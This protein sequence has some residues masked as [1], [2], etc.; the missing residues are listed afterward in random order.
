MFPVGKHGTLRQREVWH[1]SRVSA[2]CADPPKPRW[3]ASPSAFAAIALDEGQRLRAAKRDGRCFFDQLLLPTELRQFMGRPAVQREELIG[4][5]A[6]DQE[7]WTFVDR[8]VD[9]ARSSF[10]PCSNVWGMGFAWSSFIA[11]ESLL[12]VC[13]RAGLDERH[14]LAPDNDVPTSTDLMFSLAT[15][16]VMIFSSSGPGATIAPTLRVEEEMRRAGIVK[17]EGKDVNDELSTVCVGVELVDGRWWW[18]PFERMWI[19]LLAAIHLAETGNGSPAG[20]LAMLGVLQWFDLMR[21]PKLSCYHSVYAFASNWHDWSTQPV[22]RT[23][24]AELVTSVLLSAFWG[25]DMTL[26]Y[27]PFVAATDASDEFGIGACVSDTAIDLVKDIARRAERDGTYVTI[28]GI[29]PKLRTRSLG[30]PI[31]VD[32]WV[33]DF[34]TVFSIKCE[35]AEHINL[36]EARALVHFLKWVLRSSARH[37]ARVV[38]LVDSRVVVGATTKGRSG[39]LSLNAFLKRIA[40]LCFAGGIELVII[41][42]P[43]EYNPADYPSR[44]LRIPG[45][46]AHSHP[47][48]PPCPSCGLRPHVHPAHV[49]KRLRGTGLACQGGIEFAFVNGKWVH[50]RDLRFQRGIDTIDPKDDHQLE[51]FELFRSGGSLDH[52]DWD[53]C[54]VEHLREDDDFA[55]LAFA[56]ARGARC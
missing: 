41:F 38:V 6:T 54:P 44:G 16:D 26:P 4:A 13:K 48:L 18:P 27:L 39:S 3:L 47:V 22:P 33:D 19:L 43:T 8:G 35:S 10:W 14:A 17:H 42:V 11:Q 25:I 29:E 53:N 45:R 9:A 50:E 12:A 23:V 31:W 32:K 40:A 15:D 56:A 2:A 1:G 46:R 36:R 24:L 7:L 20:V 28:R 55:G 5:G 52:L 34:T 51:F 49:P 30:E 37:K 21:R